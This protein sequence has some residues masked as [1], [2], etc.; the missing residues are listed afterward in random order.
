MTRLLPNPLPLGLA[1]AL[2]GL[3]A[4][5][6]AGRA[7]HLDRALREDGA[8]L[9]A[10]VRTK[11]QTKAVAVL[12]FQTQVGDA[13]PSFAGGTENQKMAARVQNLLVATNDDGDPLTV[14]AGA[15]EAAAAKA[16]RD[17]QPLDWTTEA[18]RKSLFE[19]SLPVLWDPTEVLSPDAYVTGIVRV[20]AD[21]KGATVEMLGFTRAAPGKLVKLGTVSKGVDGGKPVP[22]PVG[23]A[24]LA[25]LGESFALSKPMLS[26]ASV[27]RGIASRQ[28]IDDA[29]AE[30][31]V[32]KAA[33]KP[34]ADAPVLLDILYDGRPQACAADP[35]AP[36]AE[37]VA[38]PTD[39]QTLTFR[40]QNT[41]DYPVGVLLSVDGKNTIALDGEDLSTGGDPAGFRLWVLKP[42]RKYDITGF[43][44]TEA[45]AS[46]PFKVLPEGESAR[47]FGTLAR[48]Y[49]GRIQMTV[50][51]KLPPRVGLPNG[52][53][54]GVDPAAAADALSVAALAAAGLGTSLDKPIGAAK[55]PAKAKLMARGLL[56]V[57]ADPK[58]N[59]VAT[60]K[61]QVMAKGLR[62]RG[63]VVESEQRTDAGVVE[64]VPLQA[65]PE[66]IAS[67][68]IRY[69]AK[70]TAT[71][72]P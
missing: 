16:R 26:R 67:R 49:A 58:G 1:L 71:P 72:T 28:F 14:L 9:A 40:L 8:D 22:I 30:S 55:T 5:A 21:L 11:L 68:T 13:A 61:A 31:A 29:A 46:A 51:G 41:L 34:D 3:L 17:K 70:G 44:K 35:E 59:L 24:T 45:G 57:T 43:L 63:L 10:A 42:G 36:R 39:T 37:A 56:N 6:G 65:D 2:A 12:K 32:G 52:Q 19:L 60:D 18:G 69:Y 54:G 47:A 64:V 53:D 20:S 27:N 15:G 25:D 33:T 62:S 7:D 50:Y 38:S 23:R 66:P 4:T 48:S